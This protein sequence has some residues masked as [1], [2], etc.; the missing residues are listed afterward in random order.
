MRRY[1]GNYLEKGRYVKIGHETEAVYCS[2]Q[3]G[4]GTH[5]IWNTERHVRER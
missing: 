4:K 2:V 5:V 1:I 3:K